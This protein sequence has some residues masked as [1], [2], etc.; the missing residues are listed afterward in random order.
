MYMQSR[1]VEGKYACGYV[2]GNRN[3]LLRP[4]CEV[5]T[6][7]VNRPVVHDWGC[8]CGTNCDG[9]MKDLLLMV[10]VIGWHGGKR[11]NGGEGK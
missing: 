6:L 4:A 3:S 11:G 1:G 7:L 9:K 2:L 10:I 8:A 5:V